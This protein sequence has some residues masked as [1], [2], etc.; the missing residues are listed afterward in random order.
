MKPGNIKIMAAAAVVVALCLVFSFIYLGD[1]EQKPREIMGIG[2]YTD[3]AVLSIDPDGNTYTYGYRD[4]LY[5][6]DGENYL[7]AVI[8]SDGTVEYVQTP[9]SSY[10]MDTD[11]MDL[12]SES[13][14]LD[15]PTLGEVE[16]AVYELADPDGIVNHVYI[17][18]DQ[19]A[20]AWE[21]I[22]TNGGT[23][24]SF[25]VG[26]SLSG[27]APEFGHSTAHTDFEA[28]DF[29]AFNFDLPDGTQRTVLMTVEGVED[30][31]VTYTN[32]FTGMTLTC[33]AEAFLG[34]GEPALGEPTGT[35]LVEN[36]VYGDRLCD[37]HVVSDERYTQILLVGVD[38]GICY[39][40]QFEGADGT[41]Y[42]G[43]LMYSNMVD[44]DAAWA[45]PDMTDVGDSMSTVSFNGEHTLIDFESLLVT[46]VP[47]DG[48]VTISHYLNGDL[49]G[50][51]AMI[52]IPEGTTVGSEVM[53]TPYGA[54]ECQIQEVV[55]GGVTAKA[56]VYDGFAL[57]MEA[58]VEGTYVIQYL[59][60]YIPAEESPLSS[61]F[62][63]SSGDVEEGGW[64]DL[65][66]DNAGTVTDHR[67]DIVSVDGDDVT[68]SVDG[69][70]GTATVDAILGGYIPDDAV[71]YGQSLVTTGYGL[72]ICDIY[73]FTVDGLTVYAEIGVS[74]G[75]F[76]G[77]G[78]WNADDSTGLLLVTG[79]SFLF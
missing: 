50:E 75:V 25:I 63:V 5:G 45:H 43:Y 31:Q 60:C 67:V 2:D 61:R 73:T 76:Y 24:W 46:D 59:C 79:A 15:H 38:D 33:S 19:R 53:H 48:D 7:S 71:Y 13:T 12:I 49:Q 29:M 55:I 11:D 35:Y 6:T 4:M 40:A 21:S 69:T 18:G 22:L 8:M 62:V 14:V 41:T 78:W 17:T 27:P 70:E 44:G 20:A 34:G 3:Y 36:P 37:M 39:Y 68:Y 1:D 56:W 65:V 77:Y 9:M 28:G 57:R 58:D 16:C 54:L 74:D 10:N 32:S 66:V 64:V 26:D 52:D 51:G 42:G 72:R 30:G 47:V 23:N